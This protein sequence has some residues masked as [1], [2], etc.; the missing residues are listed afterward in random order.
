VFV[1]S[2]DTW[3]FANHPRC[4][5]FRTLEA[6]VAAIVAM[7]SGEA[8]RIAAAKKLMRE[9]APIARLTAAT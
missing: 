4:R 9:A 7:Q 3:T 8:T 2:P 1:V 5:T 6:A